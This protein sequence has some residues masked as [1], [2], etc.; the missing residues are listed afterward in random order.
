[1]VLATAH[2]L[3]A[4]TLG[5]LV[6]KRWPLRKRSYAF[7]AFGALVPDFDFLPA[8]LLQNMEIHRAYLNHWSIP[9]AIAGLGSLLFPK[10]REEIFLFSLGYLSHIILDLL[11]F[12]LLT[13]GLIDGVLVT[14]VVFGVLVKYWK[15]EN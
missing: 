7:G 14:V 15:E 6:S 4:L 13:M 11:Q 8:L 1:M 2:V 9:F 10:Y 5:F 3:T 12:D